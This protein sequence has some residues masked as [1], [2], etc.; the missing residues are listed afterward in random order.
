MLGA[1]LINWKPNLQLVVALSITEIE[2]IAVLEAVKE[3]IW[4]QDLISRLDYKQ[5][6]VELLCDNQSA[7]HLTKNQQ[8]HDKKKNTIM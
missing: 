2:F 1:N 6:S 7:M 3:A 4:L 8:Y 5:E